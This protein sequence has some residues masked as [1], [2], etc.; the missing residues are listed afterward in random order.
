MRSYI[1]PIT[2]ADFRTCRMDA[3]E[4]VASCP[5]YVKDWQ[6]SKRCNSAPA[7]F[8]YEG[9]SLGN[10]LYSTWDAWRLGDLWKRGTYGL[11]NQLSNKSI[12]F[13]YKS[14][15][16]LRRYRN[17]YCSACHGAA[18]LGCHVKKTMMFFSDNQEKSEELYEAYYGGRQ[19]FMFIYKIDYN[20]RLCVRDSDSYIVYPN[21]LTGRDMCTNVTAQLRQ[22]DCTT[23]YDIAEDTC[24]SVPHINF[25]CSRS[26]NTDSSQCEII[27][28]YATAECGSD[29][30]F[31]LISG[32][33]DLN[34]RCL[35]QSCY[36]EGEALLSQENSTQPEALPLSTFQPK[37]CQPVFSPGFNKIQRF[38]NIYCAAANESFARCKNISH[39][40]GNCLL[41]GWSWAKGDTGSIGGTIPIPTTLI[42]NA[43]EITYK[44][45]GYIFDLKELITLGTY[46]VLFATFSDSRKG[47]CS[48]F[49]QIINS[50]EAFASCST[51]Q[52]KQTSHLN[53][54]G[55]QDF[56]LQGD[57]IWVCIKFTYPGFQISI[58][59]YILSALSMVVV[60]A[61]LLYYVIKGKKTLTSYFIVSSLMT[62]LAALIS[63]CLVGQASPG[64]VS[65]MIIASLNQYFML[66]THT[67][68]NALAVWMIRGITRVKL[69]DQSVTSYIY[70]ALYAWLAPLVL[71]ILAY[72]LNVA[73]VDGLHPI[74]SSYVCFIEHGW[75][76]LLLFTGPIFLLVLINLILC[77]VAIIKVLQSDS[78]IT[79]S[80][81][82]R[83]KR[84]IITIVKLQVI[85]GL[86][87]F[88]LYFTWIVGV[89]AKVLWQI[90]GVL[91]SLQGT[92]VVL[93]QL[94]QLDLCI[95]KVQS[96]VQ[97]KR[98]KQVVV[99]LTQNQ[100]SSDKSAVS[101]V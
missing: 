43:I 36:Y 62:L 47:Y 54:S 50:S 19:S 71:V 73:E 8:V 22:C 32:F 75:V 99:T 84:K 41:L 98:S 40:T 80:D 16:P 11:H 86:H 97:R 30:T 5:D 38:P 55:Y 67:W 88:L 78:K 89:H 68:T 10:L 7:S 26:D 74:F 52:L 70:Y 64:E 58:I 1:P 85:F 33:E 53:G 79:T 91:I 15:K 2:V 9:S 101:S 29:F 6:I 23:Q 37:L 95:K 4:Y 76:R 27:S 35:L 44:P 93:S 61:Y 28:T 17:S 48:R 13:K 31:D 42:Q 92:F 69:V 82:L 59:D 56:Y 100:G 45:T 25:S 51:H 20:K 77:I 90:L 3:E 65:C 96:S 94:I 72:V 57:A 66:C 14:Y 49:T 21:P 18:W 87:W 81:K 34:E 39:L 60:L 63:Y 24:S 46:D 83:T 12:E